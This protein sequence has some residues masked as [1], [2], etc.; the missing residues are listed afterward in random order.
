MLRI[1]SR[2]PISA[3]SRSGIISI[4]SILAVSDAGSVAVAVPAGVDKTPRMAEARATRVCSDIL[5][6]RIATAFELQVENEDDK[7]T[8]NA[9]VISTDQRR[10]YILFTV[11][12]LPAK[13]CSVTF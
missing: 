7:S 4:R 1:V 6:Y 9:A 11:N 2:S 5:S 8:L 3:R 10:V 13:L 12:F